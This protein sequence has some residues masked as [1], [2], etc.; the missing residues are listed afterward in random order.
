MNATFEIEYY[1]RSQHPEH[2]DYLRVVE[3]TVSNARRNGVAVMLRTINCDEPAAVWPERV[4]ALPCVRRVQPGPERMIVSI[5]GNCQDLEQALGLPKSR[6]WENAVGLDV[7]RGLPGEER[8]NEQ[9]F[10]GR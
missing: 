8:K 6:I 4:I 2:L 1:F 9:N 3:Q 7:F 10:R 5:A